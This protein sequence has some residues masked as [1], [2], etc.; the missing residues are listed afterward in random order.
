MQ[1]IFYPKSWSF[2][3]VFLAVFLPVFLAFFPLR[4]PLADDAV[5]EPLRTLFSEAGTADLVRAK[6][7][8][9]RIVDPGVDVDAGLKWFDEAARVI[10]EMAGEGADD[11]RKMAA[12]RTYVYKSG[13]WN[14]HRPFAYDHDDP[15][16]EKISNKL[17]TTYIEG[18]RGN[19][20]TM[21]FLVILLAER[22]GL[23]ATASTAPLHVFVK[24]TP[25]GGE[26]IN[27]EATSGALPARDVWY[28]EQLPMTDLAVA[29]GVYMKRLGRAETLAVMATVLVEHFIDAGKYAL[30]A[31]T[32][33]ELIRHYP[34]YAYLHVIRGTAIYHIIDREF[35]QRYRG[36]QEVPARERE[37]FVLLLKE[38]ERAFARAE[39]LGWVPEEG[40]LGFA[41]LP[42]EE[43]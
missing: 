43:G 10:E 5:L 30:A 12:I 8:I 7:V 27:L 29:N 39:G 13:P 35:Y 17:M 32:A 38:N 4:P 11:E 9:D 31:E 41:A 34:N 20:V 19:C 28:R 36:P 24:F 15:L 25:A 18:R 40:G 21:P 3:L 14:G 1:C 16:G 33:D 26:T 2:K 23:D 22:L 37:Y 6:L 42:M